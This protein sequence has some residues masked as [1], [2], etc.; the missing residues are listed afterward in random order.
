M[1]FFLRRRTALVVALVLA[2]LVGLGVAS[3]M[4]PAVQTVAALVAGRLVPI[5]KVDIPDKRIAISFDATWGADQTERLL[6][7]LQQNGVKTTFFLAGN[8]LETYPDVVRSI[9][10]AGHE[11]ANHS[12][13]HAHMNTLTPE[14]I[15]ADLSKNHALIKAVS[16]RTAD[17][18]RPPFGEYS[19]KV[20]E[21]AEALGYHTVQWS[22]DSLDWKNVSAEYMIDAILS[23][24]GPGDI[25][26]FH[27]AGK[28][29]PAA[30]A[31][32]LPELLRRG[33]QVVPVGELIYRENFYIEKHSG[34]QKSL[35]PA[36]DSGKQDG[37]PGLEVQ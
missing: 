30:V 6:E 32:I 34:L 13:A 18:F 35:P 22:I 26:L 25:I 1:V 29:T 27:N 15:T 17:I 20:I 36:G 12:Y 31:A 16:G 23:K 37:H 5:Y 10:A 28:N 7:I 4:P 3:V 11:L 8:W 24:A 14:Q 9:A 2:A 19:N 33:Y 21:A